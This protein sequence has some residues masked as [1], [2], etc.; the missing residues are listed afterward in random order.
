METKC[1]GDN[2]KML[3]TVLI[4]LVT[5][6]QCLFKVGHHNSKDVTNIEIQSPKSKT[7]STGLDYVILNVLNYKTA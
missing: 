1:I 3:V 4:I 6:N 7:F 2:F 5:N